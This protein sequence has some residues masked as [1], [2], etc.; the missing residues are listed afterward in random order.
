MGK[1]FL[2]HRGKTRITLFQKQFVEY[3]AIRIGTASVKLGYTYVDAIGI[4]YMLFKT[5]Y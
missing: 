2:K 3:V 5:N 4:L 1:L